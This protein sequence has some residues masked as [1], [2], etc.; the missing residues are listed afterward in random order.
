MSSEHPPRTV[1]LAGILGMA[2][3]GVGIL[4]AIAQIV[5]QAMNGPVSDVVVEDSAWS[6]LVTGGMGY[7]TAA[8]FLII[9]GTVA[10]AGFF[11][12]RGKRWGRGP[13]VM[14]QFFSFVIAYYLYDAGQLLAIIP[15]MIIGLIGLGLLMNREAVEWAAGSYSNR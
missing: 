15:V 6:G 13:V 11:L 14:I 2:Q 8:F 1:R 9:F 5:H 3:G 7:G 4:Y 10:L 12:Y